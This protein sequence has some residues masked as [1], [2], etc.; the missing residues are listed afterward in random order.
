M[1]DVDLDD[2]I[3]NAL[4]KFELELNV[5]MPVTVISYDKKLMQ[6]EVIPD[7]DVELTD[8]TII[9]AI[10]I[11]EVPVCFPISSKRGMIW[12]I[13]PGDKGVCIFSQRS[14]ENWKVDLRTLADHN[15]YQLSDA[16]LIPGVTHP[17][18]VLPPLPAGKAS[19]LYKGLSVFSDKF[20]LGDINAV[21]NPQ[22]APLG[23][24]DRNLFALL[25]LLVKLLIDPATLYGGAATPGPMSGPNV[26]FI[27]AIAMEI[28]EMT[29]G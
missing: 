5:C 21:P 23:I 12:P 22:L 26:A 10:E 28:K 17:K 1:A 29:D 19:N 9:D 8:G 13:E 27:Q 4:N 6:A 20:F 11:T 16:L 18:M 2:V 24:K 15:T 3:Q 25:N 14:L 7:F